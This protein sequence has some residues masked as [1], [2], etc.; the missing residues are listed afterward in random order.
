MRRRFFL[1]VIFINVSYYCLAQ[2]SG[3]GTGTERDPYLVSNADE[4]FEVRNDLKAHYKQVE[5]IDLKDWII[6]NCSDLGWIPIGTEGTPFSG[7]YDGNNKSIKS[8]YI[9][10]PNSDNVGLFGCCA[11]HWN[12][13]GNAMINFHIKNCVLIN[14]NVHGNNNVGVVVG[15][16]RGGTIKDCVVIHSNVE[17]NKCGGGLL[18]TLSILMCLAAML[19]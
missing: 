19:T 13:E 10:R 15:Q 8:L 5:D 16:F 4:L 11:A 7:I 1:F 12:D 2:F 9:N 3:Q 6:E 14:A 17:A 18:G